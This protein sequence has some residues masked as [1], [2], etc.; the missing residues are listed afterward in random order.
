MDVAKNDLWSARVMAK[1]AVARSLDLSCGRL[2]I[3]VLMCYA[4]VAA[5]EVSEVVVV[6]QR[7]AAVLSIPHIVWGGE[8]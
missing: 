4:G 1:G 6:E 8:L 3:G 5:R 2:A 7:E